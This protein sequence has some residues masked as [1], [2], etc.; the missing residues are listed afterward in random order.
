VMPRTETV[1]GFFAAPSSPACHVTVTDGRSLQRVLTGQRV[2]WV[3]SSASPRNSAE[4]NGRSDSLA[5]PRRAALLDFRRRI[6]SVR[7]AVDRNRILSIYI[8][9]VLAFRWHARREN[10]AHS[11]IWSGRGASASPSLCSSCYSRSGVHRRRRQWC[12]KPGMRSLAGRPMSPEANRADLHVSHSH[13]E[14]AVTR[15][16]A[17]GNSPTQMS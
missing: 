12:R 13:D 8:A 17:H 14:D 15:A 5:A 1:N 4:K 6:V 16:S 2:V 7:C 10:P 3:D 11:R 9:A